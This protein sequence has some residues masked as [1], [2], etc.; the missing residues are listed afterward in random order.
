MLDLNKGSYISGPWS[1]G[2]L[3]EVY[4]KSLKEAPC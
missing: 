1:W 3:D 2:L 4:G